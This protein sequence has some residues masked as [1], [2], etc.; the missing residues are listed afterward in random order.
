V[1]SQLLSTPAIT[2][3]SNQYILLSILYIC[4]IAK[5]QQAS[6]KADAERLAKRRARRKF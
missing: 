5:L 2:F 3:Y 4:S 1:I 6:A